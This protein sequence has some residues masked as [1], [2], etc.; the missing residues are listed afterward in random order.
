MFD[1][2]SYRRTA[3]PIKN[4]PKA[5]WYGTDT[6]NSGDQQLLDMR[7]RPLRCLPQIPGGLHVEPELGAST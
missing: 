6:V 2:S 5:V 3:R 4:R 1:E 7:T